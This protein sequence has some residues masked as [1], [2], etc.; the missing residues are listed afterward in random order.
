MKNRNLLSLFAVMLCAVLMFGM[1]AGC[2]NE[3]TPAP[4][5][6]STSSQD[7][8]PSEP[9]TEPAETPS[10]EPAEPTEDPV[11]EPTD[12]TEEPV[13]EEPAFDASATPFVD[14]LTTLTAWATS[15][16]LNA[17]MNINNGNDNLAIQ[18][19][20]KRTNVHIEWTHAP[21]AGATEAF[22]LMLAS[23]EY[24]DII[25]QYD[26]SYTQGMDYYVDEEIILD[27]KPYL[28]TYGTDYLNVVNSE[29]SI[30][31]TVTTDAGRIPLF[32]TI[33]YNIQPSFFGY[34]T[35]QAW[36]DA[37][38]ITELPTTVDEFETMLVA[39]DAG[40]Y[41]SNAAL[42]LNNKGFCNI[43]LSAF[44]TNYSWINN[45]GQVAYGPTTENYYQYLETMAR[46]YAK[47]LVDVDFMSRI[48]SY[49]DVNMFMGGEVAVYQ[50]LLIS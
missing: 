27:L 16:F 26:Y 36:L 4:S 10:E 9:A 47:G 23:E 49:V 38:G 34:A 28:N 31:L 15:G 20:E 11:D 25:L 12:T 41:A 5:T 7:S 37:A 30:R 50:S 45:N 48:H 42:Y 3:T 44:D 1:L 18:E 43:L 8:T 39:L 2:A 6:D 19:L 29:D 22:N 32:R 17:Q 24:D 33:N 13:V 40:N 46:W 21:D 35:N 14:E